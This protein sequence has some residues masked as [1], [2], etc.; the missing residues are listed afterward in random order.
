MRARLAEVG[1]EEL[2]PSAAGVGLFAMLLFTL[3]NVDPAAAEARSA[4]LGMLGLVAAVMAS[5]TDV[6]GPSEAG[7]RE[8]ETPWYE[9][10]GSFRGM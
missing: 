7:S 6:T 9:Y 5:A 3:A 2:A 8:R 4:L 1:W 10:D